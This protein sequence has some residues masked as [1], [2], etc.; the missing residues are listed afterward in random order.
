MVRSGDLPQGAGTLS[1]DVSGLA[2][3]HIVGI[4]SAAMDEQQI[5]NFWLE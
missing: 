5:A 1:L 3:P 4:S 2:G